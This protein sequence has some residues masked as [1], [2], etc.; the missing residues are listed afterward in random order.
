[1]LHVFKETASEE[2]LIAFCFKKK[3][4]TQEGAV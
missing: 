4:E 3:E 2:A 1:M